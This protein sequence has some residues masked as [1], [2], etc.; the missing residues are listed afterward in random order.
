MNVWFHPP[1][2]FNRRVVLRIVGLAASFVALITMLIFASSSYAAPGINQ[3]INFQGRLLTASGAVVPDGN[4]NIQFKIYKGGS[5][6]SA[7]NPDGTLAWTESYINDGGDDGIEVRNGF[8]SVNLGSLNPFGSSVDW[9]DNTLWLS[10]N[11]AG[12]A[13]ACTTFGTSPCEDDGEMLPMK[14]LA[15]TP[16]SFNSGML[17]GKTASN[18]VQLAQ[19]VQ[20][21]A[22][23]NTSSIHINKTGSGSLIQLQN[24]GTD[25]FTVTNTGNLTLGN[26]ADKTI[27]VATAGAGVAGRDISV[28]AGAG[29]SGA[30]SSGGDLVLQGG[31]AGG[32]DGSGGDVQINAG[33]KTGSGVDGTISIGTTSTSSVTIGSLSGA[34]DQTITIGA[35][36]TNGSNT[37]VTVGS[38]GSA[39]GGTTIV[40]AKNAV[41]IATN[42]TTRATFSDS[43]NTVYFGNGVTASAP[44]DFTIQGTNSS[45]TAVAGGSL[46]IQGGSATTGDA[47][48]GD[49]TISGGSGSGT[50][51]SGLVVLSTPTFSTVT[52]D[53]NCY[54]SGATVAT[55]CTIASTSVNTAAA[56]TVGFNATDQTATLPDPTK[57]TAGR[58]LYVMASGDS[59]EFSLAI[60]GGGN[61]NEITMRADTAASLMWNG[62]DWI[63]TGTTGTSSLQDVYN[64]ASDSVNVQIGS[65]SDDDNLT[66][67]TVDRA[68]NA[69]AA[70]D[71]KLLGSMY[72]DTTVGKLQCYEADGWGA[73]SSSPDSFVTL[74]PEYSNAVTNGSGIGTM[75]SDICSD[76]LNIN[77]GSSA[78]PTVCGTDETYNFYN[79]TSAELSSQTK[80]IYVTYKLPDTFDEF[81]SGSTSLKGRTDSS[82]ANVSYQIYLN[83]GSGLTACGSAVAV[84][85]GAQT[86]WQTGTATSTSDPAECA[87]E[88]GDS[89][90]FKID[91]SS[92]NDANAYASDLRFAFSNQ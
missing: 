88:A 10:M 7:G 64:V 26:N 81:V 34:L 77:D 30:G 4:Y 33:S 54:T 13:S 37:D 8:L 24:T 87:F 92:S 62:S 65:G 6:S 79:W 17:G 74:S 23:T 73:C 61:D 69:P 11:V 68:A 70:G 66:L 27:S 53:A 19:G 84:S 28:V 63:V 3:T 46:A 31:A 2:I 14:Q 21:D 78:Q 41:T 83:D 36:N 35:N 56:I 72:Y 39:T 55:S 22:S 52:S 42:G 57:L 90:V 48:G 32:T 58:I 51:S 49:I 45:A 25:I 15:S 1:A 40:Q 71:D 89:I 44:N 75:T 82:D 29:G 85:T 20:T 16:Y 50:G 9:N 86:T 80:S 12:S 59:E 91:L 76:T 43:A 47:D 5:G 38:G 67:L 18:F 60:N